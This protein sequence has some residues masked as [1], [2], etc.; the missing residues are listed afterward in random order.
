MV[1]NLAEKVDICPLN[2]GHYA[3]FAYNWGVRYSRVS[4]SGVSIKRGSTVYQISLHGFHS[5]LPVYKQIIIVMGLNM[6]Q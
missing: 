3:F 1:D 4:N 2:W 6:V 5:C